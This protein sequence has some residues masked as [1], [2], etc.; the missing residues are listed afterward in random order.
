M[1]PLLVS[2]MAATGAGIAVGSGVSVGAGVSEGAG[3]SAGTGV[4]AATATAV[5]SEVAVGFGWV[6]G[7]AVAS[8]PHAAATNNSTRPEASSRLKRFIRPPFALRK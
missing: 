1:P 8:P 4:S 2:T 6:M 5:G 7:V 3:V